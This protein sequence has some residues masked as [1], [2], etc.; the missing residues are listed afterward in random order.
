MRLLCLGRFLD[1]LVFAFG[2]HWET[3]NIHR[4]AYGMV[5][6]HIAQ[7]MNGLA[8]SHLLTVM[9]KAPISRHKLN[10]KEWRPSPSQHA[11]LEHATQEN[12][13]ETHKK[14]LSL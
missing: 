13:A 4:L 11:C 6:L 10:D 8:V 12:A 2:R 3:S 9:V 5:R 1:D 14:N 7:D